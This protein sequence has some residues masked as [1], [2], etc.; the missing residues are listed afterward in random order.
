VT[1][2]SKALFPT[3]Q[4]PAVTRET[5]SGGGFLFRP[6]SLSGPP[7]EQRVNILDVR[8]ITRHPAP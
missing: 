3:S 1:R 7:G 5:E 4:A 6:I 2:E 8:A